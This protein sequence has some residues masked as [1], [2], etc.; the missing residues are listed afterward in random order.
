MYKPEMGALFHMLPPVQVDAL[1]AP[2]AAGYT[3]GCSTV[4]GRVLQY[5]GMDPAVE[6]KAMLPALLHF[7]T[8]IADSRLPKPSSE[9]SQS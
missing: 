5:G 1:L 4:F 6:R 7:Q 8:Q 2:V 9:E 3:P